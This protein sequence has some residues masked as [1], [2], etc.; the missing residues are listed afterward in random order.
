VWLGLR[1]DRVVFDGSSSANACKSTRHQKFVRFLNQI[2]AR[3]PARK[4]VHVD[5][6]AT[7]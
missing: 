2:K 5:N 1:G 3:V 6:Y 7:H 4:I